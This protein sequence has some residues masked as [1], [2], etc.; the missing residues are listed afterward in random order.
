MKLTRKNGTWLEKDEF[1][2]KDE[3]KIKNYIP[4]FP[5][6]KGFIKYANFN[7]I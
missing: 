4:T 3:F 6:L 5:F 2:G 1:F 7:F